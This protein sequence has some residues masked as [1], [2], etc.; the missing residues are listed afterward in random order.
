MWRHY[1]F[2]D[3]LVGVALIRY[4]RCNVCGNEYKAPGT[5]GTSTCKAH[6]TSCMK[7]HPHHPG[8]KE[9]GV[10]PLFNQTRHLQLL[11]KAIIL[12]SYPLS[13]VEHHGLREVFTNLN[14]NVKHVCRNTILKYCI[15]EHDK[16]K[17]LLLQNFSGIVGRV[18]FT[19][20][21][22]SGQH[23]LI[24]VISL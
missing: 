22:C 14:P 20:D 8:H 11:A 10:E 12:H 16:F 13:I 5:A 2:F 6:T 15:V 17:S 19:C 21:L 23:A 7:K 1:T 4:A 9:S 18:S 3:K 24:E